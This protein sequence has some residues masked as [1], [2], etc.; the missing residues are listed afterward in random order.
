M[1]LQD[2]DKNHIWHPLTQH[3]TAQPPIGIVK[4]KG[5]LL[6]DEEGNEYID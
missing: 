5:A 6:W 2:R 3:R 1:K 4:A